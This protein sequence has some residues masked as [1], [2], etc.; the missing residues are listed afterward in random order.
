M[1]PVFVP[2][3]RA[4][5]RVHDL[6]G[7]GVP[8]VFV[9]GL[10]CASS[11]DYPGVVREEPLAARRA[12]LVDLPGS[13]FSDRPPDFAYTVSAHARVVEE[14]VDALEI[15]AIDLFGHSMGGAVAIEAATRL[16]VRVRS[17][18]LSEPN[19]DAGGGVFSRAIAA[20]TET[21][22]V[23]RG[24]EATAREAAAS[25]DRVWAG[26]LAASA[27]FA[28]HR[29]AVSLVRGGDP[30]WRDQL[31]AH[32]SRRTVLFGARSLPDADVER[33]RLA[34]LD[35]AVVPEAGHSMAWENP[36]GLAA[37]IARACSGTIA[38]SES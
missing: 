24:H 31:L 30:P 34:G 17:L 35:V 11:C 19:L 37:A 20:F 5:V 8:I 38:A 36:A 33:L 7:R 25:G 16:G 13:G 23:A 18:V 32:P 1:K 6:P 15:P 12:V 26:S 2:S 4:L 22:Y 29:A 28:I 3:A 27:P 21:D 14:A 9:H 10:G